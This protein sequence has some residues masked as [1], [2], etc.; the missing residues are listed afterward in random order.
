VLA[1]A[2]GRCSKQKQSPNLL[3]SRRDFPLFAA[4]LGSDPR[5]QIRPVA[6]EAGQRVG[7][8]SANDQGS[9]TILILPR[10]CGAAVA[11]MRGKRADPINRSIAR[12]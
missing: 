4:R 2:A 6:V 8:S 9:V 1:L 5:R 10:R 12:N 11:A 3:I 7:G